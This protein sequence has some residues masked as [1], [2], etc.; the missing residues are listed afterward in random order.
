MP[1]ESDDSI[2]FPYFAQVLYESIYLPSMLFSLCVKA[3]GGLDLK[4]RGSSESLQKAKSL[5][6]RWFCQQKPYVIV[7]NAVK[8]NLIISYG[9][10]IYR[11]LSVYRKSYNKWRI[12]ESSEKNDSTMFHAIRVQTTLLDVNSF[13]S[14]GTY[15]KDKFLKLKGSDDFLVHT[16]TF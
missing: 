9:S 4:E 16:I 11:V 3:S 14:V 10:N 6:G 15:A 8:R 2:L 1:Y 5:Q 7:D 13:Q 12:V